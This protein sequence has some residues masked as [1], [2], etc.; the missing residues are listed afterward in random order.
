[1]LELPKTELD[2][3]SLCNARGCIIDDP[4]PHNGVGPSIECPLCKGKQK[5]PRPLTV[6]ERL[7]RIEHIVCKL[8]DILDF[9]M[10]FKGLNKN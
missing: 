9:M 6:E 2:N 1:M 10:S 4:H 7:D 5:T 3:C 8:S